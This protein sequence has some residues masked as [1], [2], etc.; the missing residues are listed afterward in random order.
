MGFIIAISFANLFYLKRNLF[1]VDHGLRILDKLLVLS[2]QH[3]L[4]LFYN[5]FSV[6]QNVKSMLHLRNTHLH[7]QYTLTNQGL[8]VSLI[9]GCPLI[10]ADSINIEIWKI[11]MLVV[12]LGKLMKVRYCIY[13]DHRY[14]FHDILRGS[15]LRGSWMKILIIC[16]IHAFKG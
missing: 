3:F 11:S 16:S 8:K 10:G 1:K 15:V 13:Y 12:S 9:I 6:A 4:S 7:T 14:F 5:Y 2:K